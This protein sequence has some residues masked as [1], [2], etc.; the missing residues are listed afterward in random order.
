M[1]MAAR[2]SAA[3]GNALAPDD[4][5]AP[6]VFASESALIWTRHWV[7]AGVGEQIP[8]SG[9]LLPATLGH[10]GAH[11][12]R[13]DDGT[14]DAAYNAYQQGSC[15][16]IPAQC[17][18]GKKINC[19]YASCGHARDPDTLSP[20]DGGPTRLMRQFLGL[21]LHRRV[22]MPVRWVGPL[23]LLAMPRDGLPSVEEQL[24]EM[25]QAVQDGAFEGRT[26]LGRSRMQ[27]ACNWRRAT[28]LVFATYGAQTSARTAVVS[29]E[30]GPDSAVRL[31]RSAPNLALAVTTR[32]TVVFVVKP[33]AL[34]RAEVL[35]AVY[36]NP[37]AHEDGEAVLT[38]IRSRLTA[39]SLPV[40]PSAMA[41][42]AL[43][44]LSTAPSAL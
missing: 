23:L 38:G 28:D 30:R 8:D 6:E 24:P 33:T 18:N 44:V 3:G 5:L 37:A 12:L 39:A 31:Y 9:D 29:A 13:R 25:V 32:H 22:A 26:Y 14:V 21:N 34:D 42:W 15:W 19:A 35:V 20:E 27:L 11:V 17:G 7:A 10:H 4:G 2:A 41:E 36:S 43:G 16:Y 40:L 1:T